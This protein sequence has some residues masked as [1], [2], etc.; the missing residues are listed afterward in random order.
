MTVHVFGIPNCSTVKKSL[1]W[2]DAQGIEALFV[3]YR[4][5]P[6]NRQTIAGWVE[7][8]GT[9]AL[10]NTSGGSYRALSADKHEWSDARWVD[11]FAQDPMLIKR[12][13]LVR[14]GTAIQAGFRGTHEELLGR[15]KAQ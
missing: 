14:S 5:T 13:V 6:P 3:N 9:K 15:F 10:K 4:T 1:A 2:F 7:S 11:A 8:L 12:P